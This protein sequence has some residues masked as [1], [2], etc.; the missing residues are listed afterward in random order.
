VLV[1]VGA[2]SPLGVREDGHGW[3]EVSAGGG[4]GIFVYFS[5]KKGTP[6]GGGGGNSL[7][8]CNH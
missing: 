4:E 1:K 8:D 7:M 6:W 2:G 5:R 3:L